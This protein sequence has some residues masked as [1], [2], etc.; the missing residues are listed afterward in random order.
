M[1]SWAGNAFGGARAG[2][3]RAQ[4]HHRHNRH[5]TEHDPGQSLQKRGG[6]PT[7]KARRHGNFCLR[8]LG[9]RFDGMFGAVEAEFGDAVD[10][11]AAADP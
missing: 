1:L 9:C 10:H 2:K 7:N 8:P 4:E 6:E 11:D 3:Q 5:G